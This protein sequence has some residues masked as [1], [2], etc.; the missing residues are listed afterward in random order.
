MYKVWLTPTDIKQYFYCKAIPY[1]NHVMDVWE[2]QTEYKDQGK[3]NHLNLQK[4]EKR[5]KS[6]LKH[7]KLPLNSKKLFRVPLKSQRLMIKGILDCLIITPN[8]YIPVEYKVARKPKKIPANHKYQIT[9]YALL[10][11]DSFNTIVRKAYIYYQVNDK[12]AK[13][14]ITDSLRRGIIKVLHELNEMINYERE[15]LIRPFLPKCKACLLNRV[16]PW[17]LI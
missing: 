7:L 11:E 8:E 17:S 2:P 5:R 9:A 16:C 10:V 1:L 3:E 12:L 4:L 6:L 13:V 14:N 15:P